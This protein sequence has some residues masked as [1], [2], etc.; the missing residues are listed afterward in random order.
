M[1]PFLHIDEKLTLHLARP[2]LAAAIFEAVDANRAHLRPWFPWVDSTKGIEDAEAFIRESMAHNTDGTRLSTFILYGE[3]L[4]GALGV[5]CFDKDHRSCEIGYWLCKDATGKGIMTNACRCFIGYLFQKKNQHRIEIK[6]ASANLQSQKV[7]L[8]LGFSHE[9]TLRE[10]LLLY[11]K[12]HDM[13][14]FSIL[15]KEW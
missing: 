10:A 11:G 4:V 9:G 14:L 3:K 15:K 8:R 2:E 5:V 6:A 1:R 12:Y 13:E 7:P